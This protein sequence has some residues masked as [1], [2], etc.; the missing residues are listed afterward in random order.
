MKH[1]N[2]LL[3]LA[4]LTATFAAV[5][6]AAQTFRF[7]S[8]P[9]S[10][11]TSIVGVSNNQI[12]VG[13]YVDSSNVQHGFVVRNGRFSTLDHPNGI[14]TTIL[15]GVNSGRVIVGSYGSSQNVKAFSYN[16]TTFADVGPAGA[17][18]SHA[19]GINDLGKIAG[20]FLD[21]DGIW[22]G[23][24][25]DGVTYQTLVVPGSSAT[26]AFDINIHGAVGVEWVDAAGLVESSVYNGS[27]RTANVPN[28]VNSRVHALDAAGDMVYSWDDGARI[29]GALLRGRTFTKFDAP[30]CGITSANG[31]N[32]H[33]VIVGTC[34]NGPNYSGFYVKY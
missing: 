22:K 18:A 8:Y 7:V 6:G 5:Q 15:Y 14:G 17:S 31:I 24:T 9:G 32:D 20:D 26:Y 29:H 21:A 3:A 30:G 19:Y 16:G 10:T 13:Y 11:K 28:A 27:Y 2:T 12:A 33:R 25:Y 4:L 34:F 1:R 23:W